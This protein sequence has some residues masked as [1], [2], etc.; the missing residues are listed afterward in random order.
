VNIDYVTN[1]V[2]VPT[3]IEP[4]IKLLL[5]KYLGAGWLDKHDNLAIWQLLDNVPDAELWQTH[6]WLKE[7]SGAVISIAVKV[8]LLLKGQT[9]HM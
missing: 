2:H 9:G 8:G 3:W 4:K 7:G 6:H 5:D 1:G